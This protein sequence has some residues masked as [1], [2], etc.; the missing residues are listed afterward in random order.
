MDVAKE[1]NMNAISSLV[2]EV[3][4]NT[5]AFF[6]EFDTQVGIPRP[7]HPVRA[8]EPNPTLVLPSSR[9]L[10]SARSFANVPPARSQGIRELSSPLS[11]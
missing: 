10:T 9:N 5:E 8:A 4:G 6:A 2:D 11:D 3:V 1:Q 7:N